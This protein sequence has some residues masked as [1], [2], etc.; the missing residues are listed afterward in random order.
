M[1]KVELKQPIVD[2][3][4]ALINGA[5]TVVAV[6]YRGLTVAEDTE[7]RKTLRE[8]GVSY[9][10]Y[11]NTLVKRAAEG[12]EFAA[13]DPVLEGPT[14]IAVHK[15]DATAAA[16]VLSEF[17]KK[18]NQLEIKGGVVE[19]TFYDANGMAAIASIPSRDVL[20]G[21]LFGSMQSPI[22]N[23]ARVLN[24][25]AEKQAGPAEPAAE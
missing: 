14:A 19:G 25:I 21:R 3:I 23:L 22:T 24:Q 1:A 2:E 17:G 18:A 15:D 13:L 12:T 4:S 11:K 8:A 20:L 9:K 16:R 6:D 7:L 5:A 10:V